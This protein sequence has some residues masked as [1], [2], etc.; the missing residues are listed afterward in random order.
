MPEQRIPR[1]DSDFTAWAAQYFDSVKA[2]WTAH[3]LSSADLDA[4]DTARAAWNLAYTKAV[5]AQAAL[6][7]AI[8]SKREARAAYEAAIRPI[9]AY[10]QTFFKTTDADRATI[11]ITLRGGPALR[12]G[13]PITRPIASIAL[14][15]R[16][17]HTLRI[18]DASTPTR[19]AKPKGIIGCE[20]WLKLV[21]P[22]PA[23]GDQNNTLGDPSTFN[24]IGVATRSPHVAQFPLQSQ[25]K[26]AVYMLRWVSSRGE[27]GPWSDPYSAT[28][29]A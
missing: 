8:E 26:S 2:F 6:N 28:V 15:S 16:L 5:Q 11:G 29:A 13:S 10:I 25:G 24:F 7:A 23:Q 19:R 14:T 12:A 1:P 17:T 18:A 21:E 3:T 22:T 4:L 27:P 20:V 9:S